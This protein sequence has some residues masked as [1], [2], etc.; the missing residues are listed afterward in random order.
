MFLAFSALTV[1]R[2]PFLFR[3]GCLSRT[4]IKLRACS[5]S[6]RSASNEP[7]VTTCRSVPGCSSV[8]RTSGRR[9][10]CRLP[11]S[12]FGR[13]CSM[14]ASL[15]CF[16]AS[17]LVSLLISLT[18]APTLPNCFSRRRCN[19]ASRSACSL[20]FWRARLLRCAVVSGPRS[21]CQK[22]CPGSPSSSSSSPSPSSPCT[23][24]VVSSSS[25]SSECAI[26]ALRWWDFSVWSLLSSCSIAT[27]SSS[28]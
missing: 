6:K 14:A 2:G 8:K 5:E 1:R 27:P 4:S 20:A 16:R 21:T 7:S 25:S 15:F 11:P 10:L 12:F 13:A 26:A 19:L 23:L 22:G 17:C 3:L 24:S 9:G 18:S 28:W